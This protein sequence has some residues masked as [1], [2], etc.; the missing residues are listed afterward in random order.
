MLEQSLDAVK[1]GLKLS[2]DKI[3]LQLQTKDE[4][5]FSTLSRLITLVEEN[6]EQENTYVREILELRPKEKIPVV[7]FTGTGGAGKSSLI[8]E[9]IRRYLRLYPD[10]KL[11]LVSIDPSHRK[12]GGALLGDRLRMNAILNDRVYMRSLATRDE[13]SSISKSLPDIIKLLKLSAFDMIFVEVCG[14]RTKR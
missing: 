14:D 3:S 7:G 4:R 10:K 2:P 8:D 9:F 13:H 12:T 1:N 6:K 5:A 11:A